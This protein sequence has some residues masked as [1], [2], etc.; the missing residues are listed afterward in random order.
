MCHPLLNPSEALN[1]GLPPEHAHT[2]V[3]LTVAAVVRSIVVHDI[4]VTPLIARYR[5]RRRR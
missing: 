3:R 1:H 5:R 2:L 4:S